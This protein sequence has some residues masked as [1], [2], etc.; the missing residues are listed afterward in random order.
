VAAWHCALE[1]VEVSFSSYAG[2]RV[3]VTGHTGFKGSWLCAW[4]QSLGAHVVGLALPPDTSPNHWELLRLGMPSHMVDV[5]DGDAVARTIVEAQPEIV[6]HLAAQPLV[7]RSYVEPQRTW[8]VNVLGTVNVLEACRRV[9]GLRAIV[10]ATTDK[11]YENREWVWG[12]RESD[13]LGGRDPYSA[14][15]AACE[16]VAASYRDSFMQAQG[17]P[18]LATMRVG[19]VVGGGDWSADRLVADLARA[20]AEGRSLAVR[21]P[22][23]IRPWQH[24]LDSLS[25]Y[26][27]VG[28]SLLNGNRAHAEAWNF[29][30]SQHDAQTV[31]QVLD[32]LRRHWPAAQWH[33][34]PDAAGLHEAGVLTLDSTK[35]A[36]LLGWRPTLTIDAALR[37]TA[38]WYQQFFASGQA[39]TRS[40]IEEYSQ[41][42]QRSA[43][44][45]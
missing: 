7:R 34:Q 14:S 20:V 3:L 26:L 16:L 35:A 23:S 29:G 32:A 13:R 9:D 11:C 22:R 4:L 2:R 10:V 15:K 39:I 25:G 31:T 18:L 24:V 40:Q 41:L 36:T 28:E 8:A 42:M 27:C 5:C 1:G 30:P 17:G 12:Y 38:L 19:N 6:F 43:S 33:A 37:M 21:S 44:C 45:Q